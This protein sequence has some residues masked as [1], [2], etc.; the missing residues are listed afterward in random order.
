MSLTTICYPKLN[1]KY[2]QETKRNKKIISLKVFPG[3]GNAF[4]EKKKG[5]VSSLLQKKK[6]GEKKKNMIFHQ[7]RKELYEGQKM[8]VLWLHDD[9]I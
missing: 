9:N 7:N 8:K 4:S 5:Q 3:K 6:R 2:N 1:A